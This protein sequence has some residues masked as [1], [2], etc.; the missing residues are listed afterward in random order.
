M[1]YLSTQ[2]RVYSA[3]EIKRKVGLDP[4]VDTNLDIL[5]RASVY[6]VFDE[7]ASPTYDTRLFN[8]TVSYVI[9]G[10]YAEKTFTAS[11]RP[12]D[13]AKTAAYIGLKEKYEAQMS[14]VVGDWGVLTLIAIAAKTSSPKTDEELE[15]ITD[16]KD[17][18][19][20]LSSDID[21]VQ[22]A[23]TVAAIDLVLNS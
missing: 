11:D 13:E 21:D 7:Y 23:T 2:D 4:T 15:V 12:L 16:I 9:N 6:P 3:F 5:N 22:A 8:S 17:I 1:Y 18:S 19:T 14:A 20:N 10:Q